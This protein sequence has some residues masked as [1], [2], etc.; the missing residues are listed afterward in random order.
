ML[1]LPHAFRHSLRLAV[2]L[3]AVGCASQ[4]GSGFADADPVTAAGAEAQLELAPPA[5]G[6]QL[7]TQGVAIEPGDDV[8]WC[9]VLRVPGAGDDVYR[10]DRIEA[11]LSPGARDLIVSVA[12]PGSETEAL[13]EV[14]AHVPCTR[15]GEAFGEDL[16]ELTSTQRTWLDQQYPAGIGHTIYGGQRIA[17]DY[18]Y[19]N[20]GDETSSA[21]IK[22]NFHAST[23]GAFKR[24]AHTARFNNLTIYTPP[25]GR[26]SHLAEC[27]FPEDVW[28]G[29]LVRR[30]QQ[31]GTGF[32]VWIAGG[33]RNGELIWHST[34]P[35][36]PNLE[37]AE[38]I[39]LQGGE[40]FRF[41]CDYLNTSDRELRFGVNASDE[42]CTLSSLYWLVD[43]QSDSGQPDDCL[44]FEVES[45]GVARK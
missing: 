7:E 8:R 39:R 30:T 42:T 15:A 44:L 35:D 12:P 40:G 22:L 23:D 38:P 37:L 43:E 1:A 34:R 18:L 32:S 6:F 14:G 25:R 2:A 33:D 3:L 29:E 31:R 9:E 11:L 16:E 5:V 4:T 21:K 26:S 20:T 45:D 17:V 28:I 10:V 41:E 24:A 19:V 27:T 36:D 13:M